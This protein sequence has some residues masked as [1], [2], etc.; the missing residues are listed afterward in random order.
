MDTKQDFI[1][2]ILIGGGS[3]YGRAPDKETAI[4][5]ALRSLRDWA[6]LFKVDGVEVGINVVDVTGYG[7]LYWGSYPNG[8]LHGTNGETGEEEVIDRPVETVKHFTPE[9]RKRRAGAQRPPP[10]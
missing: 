3:S 8:W 7:D 9:R 6:G 2:I 1:A 5:H 4:K 10:G